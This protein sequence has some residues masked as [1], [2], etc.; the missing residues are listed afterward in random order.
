MYCI[1]R[2]SAACARNEK[3]EKN[4]RRAVQ[5]RLENSTKNACS[6]T[7]EKPSKIVQQSPEMPP[8][9]DPGGLRRPLASQV[10][11]RSLPKLLP[12]ASG[13]S[14]FGFFRVPERFFQIFINFEARGGSVRPALA[15]GRKAQASAGEVSAF[16]VDALQGSY[17]RRI[18]NMSP[19]AFENEAPE[20]PKMMQESLENAPKMTPKLLPGGLWPASGAPGVSGRVSRSSLGSS[21]GALGGSWGHLG[22]LLAPPGAVLGLPEGAREVPGG[23]RSGSRKPFWSA[24]VQQGLAAR[25]KYENLVKNKIS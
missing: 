1:S 6:Q 3:N 17:T 10:R 24:L 19:E 16:A 14:K 20:V 21:W 23:S 15:L 11:A 4:I 8:K 7:C 9:N 2:V 12:E 25:R 18:G 22:S 5:N 13:I